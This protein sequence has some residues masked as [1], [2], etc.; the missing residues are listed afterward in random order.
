MPPSGRGGLA[1]A[2]VCAAGRRR[3]NRRRRRE[4]RRLRC[5][6]QGAAAW[7][8]RASAPPA[9]E[10]RI[11]GCGVSHRI[12]VIPGDGAGPEVIA[13]ARKAVDALGLDLEWDE[14]D[15]GTE[16]YHAEGAMMPADA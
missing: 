5:R 16:R 12:A 4:R 1:A 2:T 9:D 15:W 3:G 13:E 6:L 14:L 10:A 8:P 11:G 7:P